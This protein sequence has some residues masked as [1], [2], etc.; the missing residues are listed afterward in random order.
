MYLFVLHVKIK[1]KCSTKFSTWCVN[2]EKLRK[3]IYL[4][5][6][7]CQ[8]SLWSCCVETADQNIDQIEN[9]DQ[10]NQLSKMFLTKKLSYWFSI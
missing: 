9:I 3:H 10:F 1:Y 8:R 5:T 6:F 4:F 2:D 7:R